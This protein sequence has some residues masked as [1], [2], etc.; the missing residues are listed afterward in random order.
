MQIKTFTLKNLRLII[1]SFVIFINIAENVQAIDSRG[2]D[3]TKKINLLAESLGA[4]QFIEQLCNKNQTDWRQYM[5][6]LMAAQHGSQERQAEIIGHFN[7]SYNSLTINYTSCTST[8]KKLYKY[9]VDQS[10]ALIKELLD[11]YTI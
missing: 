2:A 5:R 4:L 6:D 11:K 8:A 10:K 3:Y 7:H 1:M 9:H